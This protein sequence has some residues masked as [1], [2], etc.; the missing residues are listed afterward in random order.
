MTKDLY[1]ITGATGDTG[2][3]TVKYLLADGHHVRALA[4]RQDDR[5]K[6]LEAMGA[7]V[8]YGDLLN[9]DDVEKSLQGAQR[10]YFCY[11]IRPGIIQATAYFAQAAV[12]AGVSGVVNMSQISARKD[13]KSKAARDHWVAER[14]LD[15]SGLAVAHIRPTYFAEW[16]LYVAP[17]IRAGALN[18]PFGIEG[19]HAPIAAD[20]QGLVIAKILENPEPHRNKIYPLF[21]PVE[22]SYPEI[23]Q[24]V[25]RVL[26]KFIPY[27][28]VS[29]EAMMEA[30]TLAAKNSPVEHTGRA[31]YGEF[32][33]KA[34][35]PS[36]DS[37]LV[38]HL[39]EV[40]VDHTN[41]VFAGTNNYVESIGGRPPMTV[42]AFVRANLEAFV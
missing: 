8:V 11:P 20:D 17:M 15:W 31:M 39:R 37:F 41:G 40:S 16:L 3:A 22:M 42:E 33:P 35:K 5:S 19:R 30:M 10:A 9:P 27:R 28:Q 18:A 6:K 4:H 23:T 12:D 38:Q 32:E 25:G 1:L 36:G 29:F 34:D 24:E 13:S 21:G 26:N 7:E 14:V 2:S